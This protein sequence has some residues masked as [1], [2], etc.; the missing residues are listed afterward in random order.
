MPE[1]KD[2]EELIKETY[3]ASLQVLAV[4]VPLV[5]A[6]GLAIIYQQNEIEVFGFKFS[7]GA[8]VVVLMFVLSG[9]LLYCARCFRM[10]VELINLSGDKESALFRLRKDASIF[11]PYIESNSKF[12]K[13]FDYSGIY[14][15]GAF[16]AVSFSIISRILNPE[17]RRT[18]WSLAENN[19][20]TWN[21]ISSR[22]D[23]FALVFVL[24]F[25]A[26]IFI[27]YLFKSWVVIN[28]S[29]KKWRALVFISTIILVTLSDITLFPS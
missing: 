9:L 4:P 18:F 28:E 15:L 2:L 8:A 27:I 23:L 19:Q 25:S 12:S 16:L 14:A 11:N 22:P 3:A 24:S 21:F 20:A 17:G 10:L 13:L 6:V 7:P 5:S 26:A 1:P 29:D